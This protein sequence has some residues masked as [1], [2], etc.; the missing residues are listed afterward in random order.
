LPVNSLP[1][2]FVESYYWLDL[3]ASSWNGL[4]QPEADRARNTA[5]ARLLLIHPK[6]S[7]GLGNCRLRI[8]QYRRRAQMQ[9]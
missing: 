2:N 4:H 6:R 7:S 1:V 3:A 8:R 5:V 9:I